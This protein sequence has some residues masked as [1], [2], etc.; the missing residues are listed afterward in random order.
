MEHEEV[1]QHVVQQTL[2]LLERFAD[3]SNNL[4]SQESRQVYRLCVALK[5]VLHRR[6]LAFVREHS[7]HAIMATYEADST[8][9]QTIHRMT[10]RM[11]RLLLKR[12]GRAGTH[13]IVQ[14]LFLMVLPRAGCREDLVCLLKE[15]LPET[16]GKGMWAGFFARREYFPLLHQLDVR[17]KHTGI[18]IYKYGFDRFLYRPPR[19]TLEKWHVLEVDRIEDPVER[20]NTMLRTWDVYSQCGLHDAHGSHRWGTPSITKEIP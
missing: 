6:C 16:H 3:A 19:F 12:S 10:K 9:V 5:E 2:D 17:P 4:K 15:P 1:P 11:R 20:E 7:T 13:F 8:P 14:R 18:C